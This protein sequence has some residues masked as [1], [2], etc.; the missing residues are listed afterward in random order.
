MRS[1][2]IISLFLLFCISLHAAS[3]N[4]E[5]CEN[6]EFKTIRDALLASNNGDSISIHQGEYH[7]FELE[8]L[9]NVSIVGIDMPVID[10]DQK[11]TIFRCTADT[12]SIH[13]LNIKNVGTSYTKDHAAILVRHVKNFSI[14]HCSL[15]NV[16][17]GCLIE[18]SSNGYIADNHIWSNAEVEAGSGNGIHLWHCSNMLIENNELSGLRD[19]IYFEFVTNSKIKGN[20]SYKN[21]RY[22]L[23]FMFSD[24]N[25]YLTNSFHSNGAGVAVMFSKHISMK[26]NIFKQ[27]WGAA[28][29]GLL[30]KEIY[31]S[32]ILNNSFIRN[33]VGINVEGANR[34]KYEKN[35]FV[36]NGWAIKVVGACYEN[37]FRYNDFVA[38]SFDLSYSS[39]LN[40]NTFIN[41]YWSDYSG[42]DLNKDGIGDVP[43]RPVN[44]FSYIVSRTPESIVLLRSLFIYILNFSEKVS[45][46]F[47]PENLVDKNPSMKPNL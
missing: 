18:K 7:E 28:S 21:L 6:C 46:V 16:F 15:S 40:D 29:Y 34:I 4:L 10:G 36:R 39:K 11:G 14:T 32:E 9:K 47:T 42:Y 35:N 13:G 44:L 30:L 31:D 27:N 8:V 19:G 37:A 20:N 23:H 33:S 1:K 24:N 17:F 45:P 12:F 43:H 38:N 25:E 22:G 5:V 2:R 41:N 3:K 26:D